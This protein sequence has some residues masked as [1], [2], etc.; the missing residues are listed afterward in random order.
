[1]S[2]VCDLCGKAPSFGNN[3]SHSKR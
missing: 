3:V 1:M 2:S